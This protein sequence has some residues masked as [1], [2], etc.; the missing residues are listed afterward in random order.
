M[1]ENIENRIA[2]AAVEQESRLLALQD[3][4]VTLPSEEKEEYYKEVIKEAVQ[5]VLNKEKEKK[6]KEK[7]A[8]ALAPFPY[9]RSYAKEYLKTEKEAAALAPVYKAGIIDTLIKSKNLPNTE[10][11]RKQLEGRLIEVGA[12][13]ISTLSRSI[14]GVTLDKVLRYI[15]EALYRENKRLNT[16][17]DGRAIRAL[18]ADDGQLSLFLEAEEKGLEILRRKGDKNTAVITYNSREWAKHIFATNTPSNK[19]TKSLR[20]IVD[21][22][23]ETKIIHPV[24]N[25]NYALVPIIEKISVELVNPERGLNTEFLRLHPL[26]TMQITEGRKGKISCEYILGS[27]A[28]KINAILSK[29][30]E[31]R[32]FQYLEMLHSYAQGAIDAAANTGTTVEHKEKVENLLPIISG[33]IDTAIKDRHTSRL[34]DDVKKAFAKMVEIGIVEPKTFKEEKGCY[35]WRWAANYLKGAE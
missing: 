33:N 23:C 22:L 14:S 16:L 5:D 15:P 13:I 12:D 9:P 20:E 11:T 21:R 6:R 8:A 7:E 35:I 30:L 3:A 26:F 29:K 2:E 32:L 27:P 28:A 10:N 24:G 1:K 4:T 19:Q 34:K 17:A 18:P 25:G 31:Y